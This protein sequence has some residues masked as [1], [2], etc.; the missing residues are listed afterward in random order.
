MKEAQGV[1][2]RNLRE[3]EDAAQLVGR[4]RNSHGEQRVARL[5][6][7]DQMADRADAADARH[8]GRHLVKRAPFAQLLEAAKLGHVKASFLDPAVF[9]QMERDL[10]MTFDARNRID[11]DAALLHDVSLACSFED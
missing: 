7:R 6:G 9:V 2:L 11:D 3:P 4:R 5:G 1:R 8:Q 10:G